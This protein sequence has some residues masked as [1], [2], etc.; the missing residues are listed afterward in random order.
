MGLRIEISICQ[1]GSVNI[2]AVGD[3]K[4]LHDHYR[5]VGAMLERMEEDASMDVNPR[6][7]RMNVLEKFLYG[8]PKDHE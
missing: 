5:T 6:P 1:R 8:V 2:Q 7:R 3:T 4:L